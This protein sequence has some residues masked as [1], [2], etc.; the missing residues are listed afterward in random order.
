M[1]EINRMSI[2]KAPVI[3]I[4]PRITAVRPCVMSH[5]GSPITASGLAHV[6]CGA[7]SLSMRAPEGRTKLNAVAT[8]IQYFVVALARRIEVNA[9][10]AE[11]TIEANSR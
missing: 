6:K 5:T 2:E 3:H 7:Q 4:T 1:R 11:A 10:A 9:H 8:Q